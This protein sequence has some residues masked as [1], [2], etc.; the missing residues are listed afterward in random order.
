MK[1]IL[2]ILCI[3]I[4]SVQSKAQTKYSTPSDDY[5]NFHKL[6]STAER[7]YKNDSLLQAYAKFDIA[8]NSYQG[9]VNPGHYFRAALCALK[10]KEDYK[11]L[12]FLEK[13]IINGYEPDSVTKANIKFNNQNTIKEFNANYPLWEEKRNANRKAEFI[14][15]IEDAATSNKKYRGSNY[16]TAVDFCSKCLA[17]PKCNKS[18]PDFTSKYRMVK[19]K[20]KADSAV[21]VTIISN[22][23]SY[24]F[25]GTN[26]VTKKASD[27]AC[28]MLLN[29]DA[30]KTNS[31]TDAILFKALNDGHIS[32]VF[33]AKLID[34]RNVMNGSKPEFYEPVFGFEK[35]PAKDITTANKSR[36]KFGLPGLV[37][38]SPAVLKTLNPKDTKGISKA[39]MI[40]YDY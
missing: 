13:A 22:I 19:E 40:I 16:T 7:M 29:Y 2:F 33:Y 20:I 18:L 1:Q 27:L 34:R 11:S 30:D 14:T 23:S 28:E 31:R 32:P 10:I 26:V 36:E 8:F 5:V 3:V 39:Y 6:I 37:I 9:G 35:L 17:N 12:A 24:G 4:L 21:A 38:P 25:P 15:I